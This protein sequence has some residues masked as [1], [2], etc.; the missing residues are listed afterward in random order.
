MG[1]LVVVLAVVA[2]RFV[3]YGEAICHDEPMALRFF[4]HSLCTY[5]LLSLIHIFL[6]VSELEI[7]TLNGRCAFILPEVMMS[8][9]FHLG[10]LHRCRGAA[11]WFLEG[12]EMESAMIATGDLVL[13]IG[14]KGKSDD[15]DFV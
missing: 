10:K 14:G 4:F 5:A 9:S 1:I 12:A 7:F 11:S 13:E 3:G 15:Y 6:L 2:G 8:C